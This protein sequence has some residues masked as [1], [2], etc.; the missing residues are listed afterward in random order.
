MTVRG[1]R[2][3]GAARGGTS[4]RHLQVALDVVDGEP[5]HGHELQ[6]GLG[7]GLVRAVQGHHG[8]HE[9]RVQLRR[10]SQ[11]RLGVLAL[12]RLLLLLRLRLRL[13]LLL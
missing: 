12:R 3:V 10:P 5:L 1:A 11:P 8:V 4:G 7:R 6:D 13:R 9:A 2:S